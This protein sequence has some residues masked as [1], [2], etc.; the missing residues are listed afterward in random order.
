MDKFLD[1]CLTMRCDCINVLVYMYVSGMCLYE[2]LRRM[3][4]I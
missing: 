4:R 2:K 3:D 1:M